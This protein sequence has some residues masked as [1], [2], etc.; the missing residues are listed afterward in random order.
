MTSSEEDFRICY[1]IN[2]P[3]VEPDGNTA[4]LEFLCKHVGED[5]STSIESKV[6]LWMPYAVLTSWTNGSPELLKEMQTRQ[7]L[8]KAGAGA[9]N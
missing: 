3:H 6:Q 9:K 4:V 1:H 8:A 7:E 2:V 5:G